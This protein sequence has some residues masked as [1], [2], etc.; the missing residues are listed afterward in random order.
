MT[1]GHSRGAEVVRQRFRHTVCPACGLSPGG[2]H[3]GHSSLPSAPVPRSL[4]PA[5]LPA[6]PL[7]AFG[8]G[9]PSQLAALRRVCAC[10]CP[11]SVWSGA[12]CESVPPAP[13]SL[14]PPGAKVPAARR[15]ACHPR[16]MGGSCSV[17]DVAGPPGRQGAKR[18]ARAQGTG[19]GGARSVEECLPVLE[20]RSSASVPHYN[21]AKYHDRPERYCN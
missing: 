18:A 6:P 11:R 17:L 20:M 2:A 14:A 10:V 16:A 5:P 12:N 4:P 9:R 19:G 7:F 3:R 1:R 21:S 8:R 15:P 13:R